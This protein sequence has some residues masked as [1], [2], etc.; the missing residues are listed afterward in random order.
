MDRFMTIDQLQRLL[1]REALL[2]H[3]SEEDA[4]AL[5][6]F[7]HTHIIELRPGVL[8]H[9]VKLRAVARR[10]AAEI[11]AGSW[12]NRADPNGTNY[13]YW[14]SQYNFRTPYES[15]EDIPVEWQPRVEALRD[16]ILRFPYVSGVQLED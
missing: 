10:H 15:A 4:L 2:E 16:R 6:I 5:M 9:H 13:A 14:Y 3:Q 12:P 8:E 1:A 11:I 7:L